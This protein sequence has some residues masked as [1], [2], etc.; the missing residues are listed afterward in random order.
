M[1]SGSGDGE[2]PT[3]M[4]VTQRL[5]RTNVRGEVVAPFFLNIS[6]T[7]TG[8]SGVRVDATYPIGVSGGLIGRG[9]IE[10]RASFMWEGRALVFSSSTVADNRTERRG[11]WTLEGEGHL[12]IAITLQSGIAA[13]RRWGLR[14]RRP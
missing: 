8:A 4:I 3:S 12:H 5:V 2:T 13:D 9:D 6:V 14:Y 11:V 10:S 1:E 7:R